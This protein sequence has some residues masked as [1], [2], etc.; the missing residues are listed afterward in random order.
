MHR[1]LSQVLLPQP[2]HLLA[3]ELV[4]ARHTQRGAQKLARIRPVDVSHAHDDEIQALN[5]GQIFLGL[6]LPLCQLR[7]RLQLVRLLARI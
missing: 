6:H 3:E 7:P 2:P 1:I 5:L 4:H